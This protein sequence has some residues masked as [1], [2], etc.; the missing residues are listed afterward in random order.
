MKKHLSILFAALLLTACTGN[1]SGSDHSTTAPETSVTADPFAD[2]SG[3]MTGEEDPFAADDEDG[4]DT[5][6]G[7]QCGVEWEEGKE[8]VLD[9]APTVS[10]RY[11]ARSDGVSNDFGLLLFVNGFR[12]PYRTEEEPTDQ[13]LHIMDVNKDERKVQTI[14]FEPIVGEEGETLSVEIVSMLH[15]RFALTNQTKGWELFMYHSIHSLFPSDLTVTQKTGLKEPAVCTDYETEPITEEL[16]QQYNKMDSAG[17][18]SGDNELDRSVFLETLKNGVLITPQD[19]RESDAMQTPFA[20]NDTVT[21]CMYGGGTP[22]KY[23]ISAYLD[24]ELIK[25]AFDGMDYID[26]MPSHDVICKKQISPE[27]L[28]VSPG[29]YHHLYFIAVPF[30]TDK[31][32]GERMTLKSESAALFYDESVS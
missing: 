1:P 4:P 24:H 31:N 19:R 27:T 22:C 15:P 18:F 17:G 20:K 26:M 12:Q 32:Y 28:K 6:G 16:R 13:I 10:F 9:Y 8:L 7:Y 2:A 25:G 5:L 3:T 11:Y 29:E 14:E 30:Y 23:R 21:L